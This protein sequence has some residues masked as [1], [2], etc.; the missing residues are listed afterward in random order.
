MNE[1]FMLER[2]AYHKQ[3]IAALNTQLEDYRQKRAEAAREMY[4]NLRFR[5][6][7]IAKVLVVSQGTVA[8]YISDQ[9]RASA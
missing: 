5:Q 6:T 2:I 1:K 8:K 3:E 9:S 7:T 4:F